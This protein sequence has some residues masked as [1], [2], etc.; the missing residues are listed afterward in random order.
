VLVAVDGNGDGTAEAS[1]AQLAWS[2]V[3]PAQIFG[4]LRDQAQAAVLPIP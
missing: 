2:S 3:L 4:S 1:I